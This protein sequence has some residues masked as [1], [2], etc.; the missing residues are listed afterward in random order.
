MRPRLEPGALLDRLRSGGWMLAVAGVFVVQNH[1][2]VPGVAHDQLAAHFLDRGQHERALREARRAIRETPEAATPRVIA[3]LA[4]AGLGQPEP[5]AA[6]VEQALRLDPDDSRLYGTLRS[7]CIDGEREDLALIALQRLVIEHPEH[8]L[9]KLNL[10]WAHRAVGDEE[11]ALALLEAAVAAPDTTAPDEDL[12]LAHF[13]LSRV[14][15]EQERLEEASR[16]LEDAL[17]LTPDDPRLLVTA[18]EMQLRRQLLPQAQ[19][20]FEQA[21]DVSTDAGSTAARIAMAFY[22]SGDRRRAILF[23]ER[24]IA[25][26][27]SPLTLNNLAWTYAEADLDLDRA[28]ELSLRAVK[29]DADNVVYLDTYAEVLFRQGR[30]LQATALIRRCLELEPA[31]GEYYEYLCEQLDRFRGA[32]PD[33]AL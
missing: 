13:E 14:Y 1:C 26:R 21:L 4:L 20:F 16:V 3:A 6:A 19:D 23:Y 31:D 2:G 24:A 10:G 9:L 27:P 29:T 17:L 11:R 15:A 28:Q 32:P 8:W 7:I 22:N 12:V 5:A 30:T 25:E 18:G 33:T